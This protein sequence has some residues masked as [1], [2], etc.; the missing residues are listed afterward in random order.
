MIRDSKV[1]SNP[2]VMVCKSAY[3]YGASRE[4]MTAEHGSIRVHTHHPIPAEDADGAGGGGPPGSPTRRCKFPCFVPVACAIG[5]SS[6]RGSSGS[7]AL[8]LDWNFRH[9]VSHLGLSSRVAGGHSTAA[10]AAK[11]VLAV[12][13]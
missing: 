5:G 6:G 9:C 12:L 8:V 11:G 1:R 10:T 4:V 3:E 7:V 2:R 13:T